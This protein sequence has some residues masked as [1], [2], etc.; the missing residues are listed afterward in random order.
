MLG[1]DPAIRSVRKMPE[2]H[3]LSER[4]WQDIVAKV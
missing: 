2:F 4:I 3:R 1:P